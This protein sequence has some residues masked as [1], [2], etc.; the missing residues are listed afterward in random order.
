MLVSDFVHHLWYLRLAAPTNSSMENAIDS[1]TFDNENII[2][3]NY[4][5][6]EARKKKL[7]QSSVQGLLFTLE[8]GQFLRQVSRKRSPGSLKKCGEILARKYCFK[9][10][11]ALQIY[12]W[13]LS[14]LNSLRNFCC[15]CCFR[16]TLFY[17]PIDSYELTSM[18]DGEFVNHYEQRNAIPCILARLCHPK[19]F[20]TY[21]LAQP[22]HN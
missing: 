7:N 5:C 8:W 12:Q 17:W 13:C 2:F 18:K 16:D 14:F 11:A 1:D 22:L 9:T 6:G 3:T 19:L 10:S 20:R 4:A 15:Y 21:Y